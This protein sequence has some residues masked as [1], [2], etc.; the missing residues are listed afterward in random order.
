MTDDNM[1]DRLRAFLEE[2]AVSSPAPG[3]GDRLM[4]GLNGRTEFVRILTCCRDVVTGG[5]A[6]K[7][8]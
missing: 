3:F 8:D 1:E 2:S 6:H 7:R 4:V 5:G